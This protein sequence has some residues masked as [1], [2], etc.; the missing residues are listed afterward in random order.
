MPRNKITKRLRIF[1]GP[2]GSGK[3][4]IINSIRDLRVR[5]RTIDFGIY[6]NADE[7]ANALSRDDFS[8]TDYELGLVTREEFIAVVL[9]SGLV[10][11]TFPEKMFRGSFSIGKDGQ[12]SPNAKQHRDNLAQILADFIRKRLLD[13]EKKI[14]F[15]TVF[16]HKSK[17]NFMQDAKRR[18]YKI[19]LYFIATESPKNNISR[20]QEIRAI[21]GGHDVPKEKIKSRYHRSLDLLYEAAELSY[22]TYFFDNSESKRHFE[23]FAHFKVIAEKKQWDTFESKI[24][25]YWFDKYYLQKITK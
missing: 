4:T 15:E 24:I 22:Q 6:I 25:P 19:Y 3:S 12:F 20:I 9:N 18:G 11:T 14:S 10:N 21:S 5:G 2:N 23:P 7:I 16:S 17:L 13:E 1:A 8:F